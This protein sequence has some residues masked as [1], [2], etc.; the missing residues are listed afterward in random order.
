MHGPLLSEMKENCH[1][2]YILRPTAVLD[3]VYA[4]N[5]HV[6]EIGKGLRTCLCC[7]E[8]YSLHDNIQTKGVGHIW[9]KIVLCT[10]IYREDMPGR[11]ACTG[12]SL[13]RGQLD[14]KVAMVS[15]RYEEYLKQRVLVLIS[16]VEAVK[17]IY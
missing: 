16:L 4:N 14:E 6:P 9:R 8:V 1:I 2:W 17:H 11:L 7:R 12:V 13:R 3:L 5:G 15:F 10:T